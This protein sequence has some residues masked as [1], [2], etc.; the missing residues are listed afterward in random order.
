MDIT[1][2]GVPLPTDDQRLDRHEHVPRLS[3]VETVKDLRDLAVP[4]CRVCDRRIVYVSGWRV[5][6]QAA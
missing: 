2:K 4:R 6:G 5:V 3:T 1:V